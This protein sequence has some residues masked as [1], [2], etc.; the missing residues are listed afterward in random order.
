MS[1]IGIFAHS[2]FGFDQLNSCTRR[3]LTQLCRCCPMGVIFAC[4]PTTLATLN[5]LDQ[6]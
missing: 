3:T 2:P 1:W 5:H 6:Q 4:Q